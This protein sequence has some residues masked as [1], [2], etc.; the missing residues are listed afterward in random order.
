M[1]AYE[2]F[3]Y[4]GGFIHNTKQLSLSTLVIIYISVPRRVKTVLSRCG[5]EKIVGKTWQI[6]H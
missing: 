3:S 1:F 2:S 5:M 4:V 6:N